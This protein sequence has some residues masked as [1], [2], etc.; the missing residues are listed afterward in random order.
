MTSDFLLGVKA[1]F[2]TIW[3]LFTSWAIPGTRMSPAG[4]A[5]FVLSS[6]L[7]IRFIMRFGV[8]VEVSDDD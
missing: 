4:W 2:T 6:M 7:V 8:T 5:F 1:I 3:R